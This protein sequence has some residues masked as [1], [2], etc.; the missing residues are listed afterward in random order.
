MLSMIFINFNQIDT[1]I[2]YL[3]HKTQKMDNKF[4]ESIQ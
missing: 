4:A 3:K 2:Q 1:N